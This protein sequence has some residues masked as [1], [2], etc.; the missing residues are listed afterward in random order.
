MFD[1]SR[2]STKA[3]GS[4]KFYPHNLTAWYLKI[5]KAIEIE[6]MVASFHNFLFEHQRFISLQLQPC[7]TTSLLFVKSVL[8][9][10]TESHTYSRSI[11]KLK[12]QRAWDNHHC[13][14]EKRGKAFDQL[15]F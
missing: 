4:E 5:K 6:V 9:I 7:P 1:Q 15:L 14:T 11:H 3:E 2:Q 10:L 12:Y 13:A 8:H